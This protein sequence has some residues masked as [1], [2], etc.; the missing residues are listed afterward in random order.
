M[1]STTTRREKVQSLK[2]WIGWELKEIRY[3][4][5]NIVGM[6]ILEKFVTRAKSGALIILGMVN[7]QQ[8][9][10]SPNETINPKK[11]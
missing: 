3:V 5:R 1:A 10:K 7:F 4:F 2:S 9:V 8:I 11:K 6:E